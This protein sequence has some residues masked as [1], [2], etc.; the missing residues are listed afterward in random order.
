MLQ[1]KLIKAAG[2]ESPAKIEE[3]IGSRGDTFGEETINQCMDSNSDFSD[4]VE[5]EL[6]QRTALL[7]N[8]KEVSEQVS[9]SSNLISKGSSVLR[10]SE[11][12]E[13]SR[14]SISID[15]AELE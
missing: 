4:L 6:H 2:S 10:I 15:I 5:K 9:Q 13:E 1:Y 14:E 11:P 7:S 8:K 3:K 12:W